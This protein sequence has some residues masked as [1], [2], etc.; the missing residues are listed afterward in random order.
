MT[1]GKIQLRSNSPILALVLLTVGS[2]A[3]SPI[4]AAPPQTDGRFEELA[5]IVT[6]KMTEYRIPGVAFGVVKN[7]Q[8]L[9]RGFGV[10]NVEDPQPVMPQTIFPVASISKTVTATAIMRLVESGKVD[11]KAPVRRYL[12]EFQVQ[13]E[14]ASREIT[15]WNLL[16]HTAGWEG[17]VRIDDIGTESLARFTRSL[18]GLPQLAAPGT[19]WSYD[20]IGFGVAG[21]VI[22]VVTGQNIHNALRGLVFAPLGVTQAFTRTVDIV[23]RRFTVGHSQQNG[24]TEVWRPFMFYPNITAGGVSMSISDLLSYAEFHLGG[25]TEAQ[26]RVLSRASLLLM[27]APQFRKKPS[28]DEMGIGWHLRRLDGVLTLAHGGTIGRHCLH[29]QLVPERKLAFAILTNHSDG[30]RLIQDLERATLMKYEGIALAPN[31]PIAQNRGVYETLTA[32]VSALSIQPGAETYLGTYRRTPES[33]FQV[34]KESDNL[35]IVTGNG[36]GTPIMFYAPDLAYE[37]ANGTSYEFIRTPVGEVGWIRVNSRIA[38][39]D[40]PH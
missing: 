33:W 9:T 5:S 40:A 36:A 22:E 27:Q 19:V 4:F 20:N 15:V 8:P 11:L 1:Y 7:G 31:Q 12:P 6:Q 35:V 29:L 25:G 24:R 2:T 34:R 39:R 18:H 3:S 10:T 30:W 37:A 23:T 28:N 14:K 21:R 13:D 17:D 16:T 38:R 26:R 32:H